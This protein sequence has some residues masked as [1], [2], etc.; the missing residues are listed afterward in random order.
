MVST[1]PVMEDAR[2]MS[3]ARKANPPK[4]CADRL[5]RLRTKM[6]KK[7]MSALLIT[8]R[9]DQIYLTGF[10]G[11]DGAALITRRAVVLLTDGRFET[12][13]KKEA[14]WATAH[15]RKGTLA[16]ALADILRR[17][18]M[19]EVHVQAEY[20]TVDTLSSFR[21]AA[22]GVRFRPVRDMV[23]RMRIRK[24]PGEVRAIENA[25]RIAESAFRATC[26]TIRAGQTER[27]IAARLTYEMQRRGAQGPSFP[28]IV[29]EG[30]N[31]ALPHAVPGDRKIRR[32]SA[33]LLD[34]GAVA[35]HYVSDLT[36]VV[37]LGRPPK[38]IARIYE[39]TLEAQRRAI[40]AIK[41]GKKMTEVDGVARTVIAETGHARHFGHG[42]GHGIGLDVHEPP[43]L[44]Y[45]GRGR[46]EPG[47]VVT[48]EPGIYL[49]SV[50]GVRIED[51]VL[52]T[53]S[54]NRVLSRLSK[55][56]GQACL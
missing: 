10:T 15:L 25:I 30:P 39:I 19:T 52:V 47:M 6:R 32:G 33:I 17:K 2:L 48:V 40:E 8:N 4:R 55:D 12:S 20:T 5:A 38:R 24:D 46:L 35:D 49:P 23:G 3:T 45:A 21:R 54:G 28:G 43:R 13:H 16:A 18:K 11:E 29:A 56:L 34:W 22:R 1:A 14:P 7:G 50:G 51:D 53:P 36:R 27:Q 9:V 26:K 44:S 42:L 31:A 41:P 37:F